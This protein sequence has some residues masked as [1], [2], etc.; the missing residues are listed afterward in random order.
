[1]SMYQIDDEK[2]EKYMLWAERIPQ[3]ETYVRDCII[4]QIDNLNSLVIEKKYCQT[5]WL[6]QYNLD[7]KNPDREER[8]TKLAKE[9]KINIFTATNKDKAEIGF[10]LYCDYLKELHTRIEEGN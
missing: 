10:F 2:M 8:I 7:A 3:L 6:E 9:L 1:M 4:A 5:V